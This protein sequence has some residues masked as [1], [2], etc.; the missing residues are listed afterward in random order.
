MQHNGGKHR[1]WT[2]LYS[3]SPETPHISPPRA[4][5]GAHAVGNLQMRIH[6]FVIMLVTITCLCYFRSDYTECRSLAISQ[7]WQLSC[8]QIF[9]NIL[10]SNTAANTER[11]PHLWRTFSKPHTALHLTAH[12]HTCNCYM[13][14]LFSFGVHWKENPL[15]TIQHWFGRWQTHHLIDKSIMCI[16]IVTRLHFVGKKFRDCI[17]NADNTY[18]LGKR[19]F[20]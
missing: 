20:A 3:H 17:I 15:T 19:S 16:H 1:T 4:S 10:Y 14:L 11:E 8:C 9:H 2:I 6:I 13:S 12:N 7:R 5:Y 18:W